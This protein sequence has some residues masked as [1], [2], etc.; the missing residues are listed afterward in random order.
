M[1]IRDL[2]SSTCEAESTDRAAVVE[3]CNRFALNLHSRFADQPGNLFLSPASIATALAMTYA[4]AGGQT[5]GEMAEVLCMTLPES[6]FHVGFRD[7]RAAMR[8]GAIELRSANRLFGQ[9]G[10]SFLP[11]FLQTTE[12]CYGARLAEVDF[13]SA[14]EEARQQIN[15]WVEEQTAQKIRDLVPPGVLTA[16]TRLVLTNAVYFNGHWEHEFDENETSEAP[17]WTAPGRPA[18]AQMMQQ[19]NEFEYGEFDGLQVLELP[20]REKLVEFRVN[21][22]GYHTEFEIPDSGSDLAMCFL[23]PR[24]KDG[25]PEIESRLTPAT[26]LQWTTLRT[27]NVLAA[28]PRF[29]IESDFRLDETLKSLGMPR[30]FSLVQADFTRMSDNPEGLYL[31]AALH[32]AFVDVNEEG[33]E[34]AAATVVVGMARGGYEEPVTFRADHPF[35]FLIRDRATR[36]LH[37]LGRCVSPA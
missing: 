26:L 20:Y 29:R 5:A 30:A 9:R 33:T 21:E 1:A 25:L 31:A 23:L 22:R 10:Y 37:F 3:S 17:F 28:I 27:R 16:L 14:T 34:A 24:R 36:L 11:A 7:L 12:R 4:G 6:R 19:W 18:P 35:L 13:T 8:T 15:A 32:K 2:Q